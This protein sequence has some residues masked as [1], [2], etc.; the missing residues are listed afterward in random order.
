MGITSLITFL[1]NAV[2]VINSASVC[3]Y[4]YVCVC[5][6]VCVRERERLKIGFNKI[7]QQSN[8]NILR[9]F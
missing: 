7:C 3:V 4:V 8:K 2:C 5:V 6:C 1:F 9:W